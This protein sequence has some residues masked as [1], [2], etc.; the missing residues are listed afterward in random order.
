MSSHHR[1]TT[2][3]DAA[4]G[5]HVVVGLWDRT[6]D[7]DRVILRIEMKTSAPVSDTA[8]VSHEIIVESPDRDTLV[9]IA[10]QFERVAV[11]LRN[12]AALLT[13]RE[14]TDDD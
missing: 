10:E 4:A 3:V 5:R 8:Y 12:T 11:N 1:N 7:L 9:A 6:E 14:Q 2:T 13:V